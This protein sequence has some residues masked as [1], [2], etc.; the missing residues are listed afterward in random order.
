MSYFK[1]LAR[2]VKVFSP[3]KAYGNISSLVCITLFPDSCV[4]SGFRYAKPKV[5]YIHSKGKFH[6]TKIDGFIQ[7]SSDPSQPGKALD[8]KKS[9]ITQFFYVFIICIITKFGENSEENIDIC[10]F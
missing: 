2:L 5:R 8:K 9:K 10:F 1:Y 3:E 6:L 4:T 7:R